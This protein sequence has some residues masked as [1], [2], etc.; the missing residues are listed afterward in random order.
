MESIHEY[1]RSYLGDRKI[2]LAY[3]IRKDQAVPATDP[4]YGYPKIGRAHV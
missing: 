4:E 1:L 3:V 2:P